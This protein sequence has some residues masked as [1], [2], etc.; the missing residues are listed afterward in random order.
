MK[1]KYNINIFF[2]II[3]YNM[4]ISVDWKCTITTSILTVLI[5]LLMVNILGRFWGPDTGKELSQTEWYKS[6]E[7]ILFVSAIV[8]YRINGALFSSCK[9]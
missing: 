4:N 3:I 7:I 5:Y 8:A 1:N 9:H 6:L 2:R